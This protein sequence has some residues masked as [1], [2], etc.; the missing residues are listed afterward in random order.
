[1]FKRKFSN[2]LLYARLRLGERQHSL[3]KA[4]G[5]KPGRWSDLE[6]GR[7]LP[8]T[9]ETIKIRRRL[10]LGDF[11]VAPPAFFRNLRDASARWL[12]SDKPYFAHQD[13]PTHVR[14][15]ACLRDYGAI[16][17]AMVD[18]VEARPDFD[19]CQQLCHVVSC[20]STL[21]VL[22]LLYLLYLGAE[23]GFVRPTSLGHTPCPIVDGA[24][25][26]EVGHR[27]H[28]CL[29]LGDAIYFFQVT[30]RGSRKIRVDVLRWNHGWRVFE[31]NGVGH[32]GRND[33]KRE[34][35]LGIPI[36]WISEEELL[37]Q[38]GESVFPMT[39]AG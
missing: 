25:R 30:F 38:I 17:R 5:I 4:C 1:M 14:Y 16:A 8:T 34:A 24:T 11:F 3:A 31:L 10:Q 33:H 37:R 20:D 28:P 26:L 2:T 6:T 19:Y 9:L 35:E 39:K 18:R 36:S 15:R 13:R 22:N 7:R 21:E 12:G 32:I 23:P 27:P 29:K